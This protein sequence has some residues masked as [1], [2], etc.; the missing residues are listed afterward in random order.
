M[1]AGAAACCLI[2][3]DQVAAFVLAHPRARWVFHHVGFDFW[4][5][6]RHLRGIHRLREIYH[7]RGARRHGIRPGYQSHRDFHQ[8]HGY[9]RQSS[10]RRTG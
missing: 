8:K 6:A 2:H 3:P 1:A 10:G 4:V 7:L 5:V 9:R